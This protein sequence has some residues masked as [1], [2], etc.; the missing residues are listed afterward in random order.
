MKLHNYKNYAEYKAIQVAANKHTI[1]WSWVLESDIECISAEIRDRIPR[2]KFGL[3]HGTRRGNEQAWFKKY[4]EI[5]VLGTEIS[6]T[7]TQFPDTIEWDFHDV[8]KEWIGNVDFVYSNSM[9]H[10]YKPTMALS[11]WM[12]CLNLGGYCILHW[13]EG[14]LKASTR[15]P[16]GATLEEY[17]EM[18]IEEGY[19]LEEVTEGPR[20]HHLLWIRN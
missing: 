20:D 18:I 19:V 13:C 9:D 15:D 5:D 7:A 8:K 3:C 2:L 4:L 11:Q 14:Q 10:S 12:R 6:D 1:T 16:F 17:K